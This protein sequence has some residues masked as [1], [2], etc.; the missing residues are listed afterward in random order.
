MRT[1]ESNDGYTSWGGIAKG[2]A[3]GT[4][5][6]I[7]LGLAGRGFRAM[8]SPGLISSFMNTSQP[9]GAKRAMGAASR[10]F[11]GFDKPASARIGTRIARGLGVGAAL[12][13]ASYIN[14]FVDRG[15]E[16]SFGAMIGTGALAVGAAYGARRFFGKAT[17]RSFGRAPPFSGG[18]P[19]SAS[20]TSWLGMT[21][22]KRSRI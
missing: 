5:A 8:K 11:G 9:Y 6:L 2:A 10:Y 18:K 17:K 21:P 3:I 19:F 7:G 14:P 15:N 4:G 12:Y 1:L 20:E 16:G 22:P 13:G